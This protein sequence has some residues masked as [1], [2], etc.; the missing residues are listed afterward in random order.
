MSSVSQALNIR[1]SVELLARVDRVRLWLAMQVPGAT[2]T[3][4]VRMVLQKGLEC[5]EADV[6]AMT[7]EDHAWMGK[8]LSQLG[9]FEPYDFGGADPEAL[10]TAIQRLP[11]G[12]F[13]IETPR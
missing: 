7:P 10:G 12:G 5:L 2:R 13:V 8:D 3:D 11:T 1:L 4:A 6:E 9:A